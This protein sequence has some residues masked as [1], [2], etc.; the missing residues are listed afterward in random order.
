MVPSLALDIALH[1]CL[2]SLHFDDLGPVWLGYY[3]NRIPVPGE[4]HSYRQW[5][6]G[7]PFGGRV[8]PEGRQERAACLYWGTVAL[9]GPNGPG[10]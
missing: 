5:L 8:R 4:L 3:K 1:S 10:T 9:E 2:H 7:G 6:G